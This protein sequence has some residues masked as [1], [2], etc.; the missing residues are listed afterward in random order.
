MADP[1]NSGGKCL[2]SKTG[3]KKSKCVSAPYAVIKQS[4]LILTRTAHS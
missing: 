2:F 4:D 1:E 3:K